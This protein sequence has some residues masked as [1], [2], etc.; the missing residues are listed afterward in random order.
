MKTKH[1]P[2]KGKIHLMLVD[3]HEIM[4]LGLKALLASE[5]DL[6]VVAEAES[7]EIALKLMARAEPDVVLMDSSMPGMSGSETTRQ[8]KKQWPAVK[9]IGL[10]L[11]EQSAYLDEMV[12]SGAQ[13]FVLKSSAPANLVQAVRT[14]AAGGTYF[15][16]AV[17][18]RSRT[19]VPSTTEIPP[20]PLEDLSTDELAVVK[21]L[22]EGQTNAEIA[23][24]LGLPPSVVATHRTEAMAKLGVHNRAELAR[25]AA[26]RQW[27]NG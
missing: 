21:L 2:P 9:V 20:S 18:R 25:V 8:L 4:R 12:L 7:G 26:Q 5:R 15:D 24:T 14:V 19:A 11:Y 1:N 6:A 16:P 10:T 27:L 13:G 3:D 17:P 23:A 22:A